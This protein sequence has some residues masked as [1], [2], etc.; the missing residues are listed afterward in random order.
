LKSEFYV[1][2]C[3]FR[4][5]EEIM[6]DRGFISHG[7][8]PPL[9]IWKGREE[10]REGPGREYSRGSFRGSY[11]DPGLRTPEEL[12]KLAP[13]ERV[14]AIKANEA[15]TEAITKAPKTTVTHKEP[16]VKLNQNRHP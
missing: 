15:T 14:K 2:R 10:R 8:P 13:A 11:Y 1:G 4:C 5:K 7:R 9:V 3:T 6:L 12:M 16:T